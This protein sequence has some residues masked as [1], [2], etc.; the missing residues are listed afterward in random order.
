LLRRGM[1]AFRGRTYFF[2][3]ARVSK[4]PS[5]KQDWEIFRP[6]KIVVGHSRRQTPESLAIPVPAWARDLFGSSCVVIDLFGDR[7][8]SLVPRASTLEPAR[9]SS[10]NLLHGGFPCWGPAGRPWAG[11]SPASGGAPSTCL[12]LP[13][14]IATDQARPITSVRAAKTQVNGRTR[15]AGDLQISTQRIW[16]SP[17]G[18]VHKRC[19]MMCQGA[20]LGTV[21]K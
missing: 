7:S 15:G 3:L 11:S 8:I 13:N 14:H 19:S 20:T 18:G 17:Q 6:T 2:F 5:T 1:T 9:Q 12:G 21:S 16:R 4:P 10:A